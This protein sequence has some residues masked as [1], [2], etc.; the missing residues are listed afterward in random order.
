MTDPKDTTDA[1]ET[2]AD[3]EIA[4]EDLDAVSGGTRPV[5]IGSNYTIMGEGQ[6]KY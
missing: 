4:A 5:S 6:N 1:S 3:E 2:P